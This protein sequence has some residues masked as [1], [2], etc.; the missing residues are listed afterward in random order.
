MQI[1]RSSSANIT[2]I[3]TTLLA[4]DSRF[5]DT[6][7]DSTENDKQTSKRPKYAFE[8]QQHSAKLHSYCLG[9]FT[10]E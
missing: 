8:R 3:S 5:Q 1:P 6:K 9:K 2:I 7:E 4:T 10:D